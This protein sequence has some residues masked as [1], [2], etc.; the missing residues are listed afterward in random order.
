MI[1]IKLSRNFQK[2]KEFLPEDYYEQPLASNIGVAGFETDD[3]TI[4]GAAVISD[5][6]KLSGESGN[7]LVLEWFF[8]QPEHR[9]KGIFRL[10]IKTLADRYQEQNIS[11]II[12]KL[13]YPQMEDMEAALNQMGFF[14]LQD[15]N[16]VYR[17]DIRSFFKVRLL[18]EEKEN[19][20][21]KRV[22]SFA[23]CTHD[24][25]KHFFELAGKKYPNS[26]SVPMLPG[27]WSRKLSYIYRIK[28]E[29]AGFLLTSILEDGTLYFG[30]LY[31]ERKHNLAAPALID[32]LIADLK[33]ENHLE[34][35]VVS[36]ASDPGKR[37]AEH[38]IHEAGATPDRFT[39]RH[40][41]LPIN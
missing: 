1:Q 6:A 35:I 4:Y 33:Q 12:V 5:G 30:A 13:V 19:V 29:V 39:V 36:A 40:Y 41:Y 18:P 31:A 10:L 16:T 22:T 20:L 7:H 3:G 9:K 25:C 27:E 24:D 38:I 14:R 32:R 11:G 26:L 23:D 37:I 21:G 2:Y 34:T 8:V 15:G 17:G 28:N